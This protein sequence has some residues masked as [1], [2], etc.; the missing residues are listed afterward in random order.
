MSSNKHTIE[1]VS[2][3]FLERKY[4]LLSTEYINALAKLKYQ[5]PIGHIHW[6]NWNKFSMGRG[7]PDCKRLKM[8]GTKYG[9]THGLSYT[10]KYKTDYAKQW[11][12][13]HPWDSSYNRARIRCIDLNHKAYKWYGGKG[14]K[15]LITKEE[16]EEIW[17]R[18]KA[19]LMKKPSIDR[20]DANKDYTYKNCQFLELRDNVQKMHRSYN[21]KIK[22]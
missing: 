16:I 17:F 7:C 2:S 9:L 18:D 10:K 19:Y 14:I 20:L 1:F 4:L 5:C 21:H 22:D 13:N 3:K 12:K 15:F 11:V 6:M 8:L